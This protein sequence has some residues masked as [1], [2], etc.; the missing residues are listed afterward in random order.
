MATVVNDGGR[1]YLTSL[2]KLASRPATEP[3]YLEIGT[4][5]TDDTT[6][7]TTLIAAVESRANGTAS[8]VT[9]SIT[10]DT[11]RTVGTIT[12]TS[13]RSV[14]EAGMFTASSAGTMVSRSTFTAVALA[15][16]DSIQLTYDIKL[17]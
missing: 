16:G 3:N 6:S 9:G 2:I 13:A 17:A 1:G 15:I 4:T 11:Y 10:N 7:R 5:A 8:Q 12:A 14:V